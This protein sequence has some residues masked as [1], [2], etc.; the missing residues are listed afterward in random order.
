MLPEIGEGGQRKL[1]ASSVLIVGCGALGGFQAEL[2]T[3]AGVGRLRIADADIVE[4]HNLHRQI[5]YRESDAEAKV[6]KVKA[7]AKRLG[8]VNSG[9]VV[10]TLPVRFN[11][12][13]G[14]SL[15][16][17]MD[18]VLDA[19]DNFETRYL[20]NDVC[21]KLQ[22]PW[23]YGGVVGTSG[24]VMPVLPGLRGPCLRCVIPIPP[25][26]G[27]VASS[28]TLGVLNCAVAVIASLQATL[29]MR[30]LLGDPPAEIGLFHANVWNMSFEHLKVQRNS[31]CPC[32][33]FGKF[34][35]L[36]SSV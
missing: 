22:K 19:T 15:L 3:R 34:E 4:L 20:L 1:G 28:D 13:N 12:Q 7:A 10:E 27:T 9:V 8:E 23:I 33:A 17:G 26:P 29:A 14:Q 25:E 16:A 18:L 32:C 24:M 6:L 2:L 21:I 11:A 35:F 36:D 31:Q 5:L 30:I